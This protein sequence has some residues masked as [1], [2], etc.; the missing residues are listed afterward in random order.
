MPQKRGE[1]EG[2]TR[3]FR[4]QK[5][6]RNSGAGRLLMSTRDYPSLYTDYTTLGV[7]DDISDAYEEVFDQ[8]KLHK[9]DPPYGFILL[10]E[11]PPEKLISRG[12]YCSP[13]ED[14]S[15]RPVMQMGV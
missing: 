4:T 14:D 13:A 6:P 8:T 7:L 11:S 9:A 5:T 15:G 2:T 1:T 3:R 12:R 10:L